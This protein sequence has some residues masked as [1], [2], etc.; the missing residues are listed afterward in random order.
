MRRLRAG[1]P[2]RT[3]LASYATAPPGD[4]DLRSFGKLLRIPLWKVLPRDWRFALP[5]P[6]VYHVFYFTRG[7][8]RACW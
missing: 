2:A 6:Q 3:A 1:V 7:A 4:P 5:C 8:A